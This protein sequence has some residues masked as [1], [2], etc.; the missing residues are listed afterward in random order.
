ME[1]ESNISPES[2][3]TFE[4]SKPDNTV[5]EPTNSPETPK[6]EKSISAEKSKWST[7]IK[8]ILADHKLFY[9]EDEFESKVRSDGRYL[10]LN[11]VEF[12]PTGEEN[13]MFMQE[14]FFKAPLPKDNI[15]EERK[16]KAMFKRQVRVQEYL[17]QHSNFPITEVF[18]SNTDETRGPQYALMNWYQK[19]E[20]LGFLETVEDSK[21]LS[22]VHARLAVG[23]LRSL[24][25]QERTIPED[26]ESVLDKMPAYQDFTGFKANLT[27]IL[28]R[29]VT[30]TDEFFSAEKQ[31]YAY[32]MTKKLSLPDFV[33]KI[34]TFIEQFRPIV[35]EYQ[36]KGRH[37][38]H[39]DF[40]PN[41]IFLGDSVTSAR[42]IGLDFE[43]AGISNNE[44]LASVYDFG[45]M[46]SRA[47]ANPN[48][49]NALEQE[50]ISSYSTQGRE[51]VG[52]AIVALGIL[53]SHINHSS[54]FE[55]IPSGGE[56][57]EDRQC[58]IGTEKDIA[59]AWAIMGVSLEAKKEIT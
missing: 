53:R 27:M 17:A 39:G 14:R 52:K 4:P 8:Q 36:D 49:Q 31:I 33:Q 15:I 24:Q 12:D 44:V 20:D 3:Q 2:P 42:F 46:H 54:F 6:E 35:D 11:V 40:S 29:Q 7:D 58:R 9:N 51:E 34:D 18:E 5:A 56:S 10:A 41:N 23:A 16:I 47:W 26:L 25:H 57:P 45:N 21:K 32:L 38:V 48:F 50:M 43:W 37:L 59:K 13:R 55:N 19:G 1:T 30:G 22:P 28:S